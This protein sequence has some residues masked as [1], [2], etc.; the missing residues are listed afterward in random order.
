MFLL[1]LFCGGSQ[2]D[3]VTPY[4]SEKMASTLTS[5]NRG[6]DAAIEAVAVISHLVF[7]T[8]GAKYCYPARAAC[9]QAT[10]EHEAVLI[11]RV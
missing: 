8:V 6:A 5:L 2:T 4:Y 3:E 9:V 1:V 10:T 11:A 7:S